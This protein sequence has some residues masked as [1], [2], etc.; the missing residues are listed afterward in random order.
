MDLLK[1]NTEIE[2]FVKLNEIPNEK[3]VFVQFHVDQIKNKNL[4][5]VRL[6]DRLVR[7]YDSFDHFNQCI[8]F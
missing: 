3:I 4:E 5:I 8:V 1:I 2:K 6:Y 7:T